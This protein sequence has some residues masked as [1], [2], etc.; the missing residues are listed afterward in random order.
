MTTLDTVRRLIGRRHKISRQEMADILTALAADGVCLA[1]GY[2]LDTVTYDDRGR[3]VLDADRWPVVNVLRAARAWAN[4]CRG[5]C[6]ISVD[7]TGLR[8]GQVRYDDPGSMHPQQHASL[9]F[10]PAHLGDMEYDQIGQLR[11]HA[12]RVLIVRDDPPLPDPDA[13]RATANT[14]PAWITQARKHRHVDGTWTRILD[15][16]TLEMRDLNDGQSSDPRRKSRYQYR[17]T[18]TGY[19]ERRLPPESVGDAWQDIGIPEWEYCEPAGLVGEL[20]ALMAEE[21][22]A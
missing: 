2:V 11:E 10:A 8:D 18:E 9:L 5:I 1:N 13:P 16:G 4:M 20:L 22:F 7:H 6:C 19:Q 14:V 3:P 17:V 12:D 21:Q 15:D